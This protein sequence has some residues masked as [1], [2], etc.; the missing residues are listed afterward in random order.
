MLFR[1][2]G[3]ANFVDL[4]GHKVGVRAGTTTEDGLKVALQ[5]AG[6]AAQ[7]VAVESHE[8]GRRALEAG[9]ISAY[10]AD[11]AILAM[12]A[13]GAENSGNLS[14]SNRFF[15]YEPYAMG[16]QL[17]DSKFRLLVDST[18]AR[19]YSSPVIGEIY[20]ASFG[21]SKVSD[22]LRAMYTLNSLPN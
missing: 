7:I 4:A 5:E 1:K 22:L 17:G 21:N 18:L 11:R 9:E 3:P 10:F 14:L 15:S 13:F 6:I 16:M 8:D 19:V 2:D 20:K 12:L